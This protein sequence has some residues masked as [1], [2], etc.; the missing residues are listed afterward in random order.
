MGYRTSDV[1][2][3]GHESSA[4]LTVELA[5]II[6]MR[7]RYHQHMARM[8]LTGIHERHYQRIVPNEACLRA[9]C[10]YLTED[11]FGFHKS[12]RSA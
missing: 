1:R 2:D 8:E 11:A 7:S 5:S 3:S 6:K 10:N 4:R 9:P 12:L